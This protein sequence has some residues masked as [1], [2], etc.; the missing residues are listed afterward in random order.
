MSYKKELKKIKYDPTPIETKVD[1]WLNKMLE[2]N[3]KEFDKAFVD[4]LIKGEARVKFP[5]K[6][7]EE[8]GKFLKEEDWS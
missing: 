7:A 8:Y 5:F 1:N 2:E 6:R 4:L 3:R